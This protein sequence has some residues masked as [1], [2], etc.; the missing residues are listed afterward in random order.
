M[1]PVPIMLNEMLIV[2]AYLPCG[3]TLMG[4]RSVLG[5]L[6]K[7]FKSSRHRIR[8]LGCLASLF[9]GFHPNRL[10]DL[11]ASLVLKRLIPMLDEE[12][13]TDAGESAVFAAA[14]LL[15]RRIDLMT[16][17]ECDQTLDA[18][19][20]RDMDNITSAGIVHMVEV[21]QSLASDSHVKMLKYEIIG[22]LRGMDRQHIRTW[23][24]GADLDSAAPALRSYAA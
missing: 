22:K 5:F 13:L 6:K 21:A 3:P 17:E 23:R 19:Q 7:K 18:L 1:A 4:G 2:S 11:E 16:S 10:S 8:V 14:I 9:E 15:G 20:G 24:V 12:Q